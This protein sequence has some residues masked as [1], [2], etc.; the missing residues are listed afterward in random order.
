MG[1]EAAAGRL[2]R[3]V[4]GGVREGPLG[5]RTPEEILARLVRKA[6]GRDD[7]G[8]LEQA[9]HFFSAMSQVRGEPQKALA[10]AEALAR[11][12]RL[13]P[14]PLQGLQAVLE[15][16]ALYPLQ[17]MEVVVDLGLVRGLAYY[18]G[19][20]FDLMA[21]DSGPSLGG[22]GRYDGLLKALGASQDIPAVGFAY[23][24]ER[25]VVSAGPPLEG[26]GRRPRRTL[27]APAQESAYPQALKVADALRLSG[28]AV[29]VAHASFASPAEGLGYARA[30]RLEAL[31]L[32]SPSG[33]TERHWVGNEGGHPEAGRP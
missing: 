30:R 2:L 10:Q 6:A 12:H 29:E 33:A 17:G 25:V 5:S 22:G 21:P 20:V 13:A 18:T 15:D 11:E 9:L 24:L 8:R 7:P 3:S 4:M 26:H 23:T 27:V 16:L 31:V 28:E 1:D 14:G 19:V 32:V